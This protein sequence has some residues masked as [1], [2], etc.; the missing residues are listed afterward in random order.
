LLGATLIA[1]FTGEAAATC[2]GFSDVPSI[3]G[4]CPSIEWVRNRSIT[5]GCVS[6]TLYCPSQAVNRLAM[7]AFLNRLGVALTPVELAAVDPP[8]PRLLAGNPVL[9]STSDFVVTGFPRRAY[10]NGGVNLSAPGANVV[11]QAL[12]VISLDAGSTWSPIQ[13]SSVQ[14]GALYADA[15]APDHVA[16]APFGRADL[17][18]GQ[19]VR[20]GMQISAWDGTATVVSAGCQ[21]LVRIGNRNT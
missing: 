17:H 4:F 1:I 10:V 7:A 8:G 16:L 21:N 11:V 13:H 2:A 6:S 9:C 19:V 12:L 5:L 14:Y 18:V 3:S 15:P 20:F